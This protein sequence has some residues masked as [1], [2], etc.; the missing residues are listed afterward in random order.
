MKP[1]PKNLHAPPILHAISGTFARVFRFYLDGFRRMTLGRTLWTIILVKLIVMF[2]VL[3][4]FFFPNYLQSNFADDKA[5][6]EHVAD[7]LTQPVR[8]AG[9]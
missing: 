4:L 9:N 3:K 2:A 1:V 8:G 5:R 7:Q 6:A